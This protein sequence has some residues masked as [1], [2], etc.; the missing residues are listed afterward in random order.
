MPAARSSGSVSSKM[1]PLDRARVIM[2]IDP[3]DVRADAAQLGF[4]LVVAA[5]QVVDAIDHG[6]AVGHQAGD[7]QAGGGAQVGG[8]D[9][10]AGQRSTPSI[11]ATLPSTWIFAPRRTSSLT[12]MK[13]FSKMVSVT[14]EA[15]SAMRSAP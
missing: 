2:L 13:R 14:C 7:D 3:F 4:H 10:R 11:T 8:H 12:C 9:G 5:V 1:R 15:P 6:L